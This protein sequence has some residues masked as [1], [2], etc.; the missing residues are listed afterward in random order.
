MKTV[1]LGDRNVTLRRVLAE[2]E[3]GE[4]VFL[5]DN[6]N[7]RFVLASADDADREV[8]ALRSNPA[9]MAHLAKLEKRARTQPRKTLRE[10]RE[11]FAR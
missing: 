11:R 1:K 2:A 5:M 6:G 8:F 7:T 4:V 9:F 10:I 3:G